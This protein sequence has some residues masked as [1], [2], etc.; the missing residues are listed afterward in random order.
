MNKIINFV[1]KLL[2][3]TKIG[4]KTLI[5]LRKYG[6]AEVSLLLLSIILGFMLPKFIA[7]LLLSWSIFLFIPAFSEV[8][9]EIKKLFTTKAKDN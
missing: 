8:V 6:A 9:Y 1:K 7:I 3:Y 4:V 5:R 2:N